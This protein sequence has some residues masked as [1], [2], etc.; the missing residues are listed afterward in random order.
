MTLPELAI[1]RPITTLVVLVSLLTLGIVALTRLPLAFM[2]DIEEPELYVHVS[3]PQ[4]AP[5][6]VEQMIARPLEDAVGSVKGLKTMWS[7]SGS[8]GVRMRLGFDWGA[9][10]HRARVEIWERIDR[11]RRDLPEDVGDIVVSRSW[12][13][14]EEEMENVTLQ[15]FGVFGQEPQLLH[16][17]RH[18]DL[19][20]PFGG[21]NTGQ[22]VRNRTDPA[23]TGRQGTG[24]RKMLSPKHHLE[25]ARCFDNLPFRFPE[26]ALFHLYGD[27]PVPLHPGEMF[28][29]DVYRPRHSKPSK[30]P[31]KEIFS[32]TS[33]SE[34]P[35]PRT[36]AINSATSAS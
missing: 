8:D 27:I 1:K 21:A 16:A 22:R 14:Q 36:R 7:R 30:P 32:R 11:I 24:Q 18:F 17:F 25:I 29:L 34:Y 19:K 6:Q 33:L 13:G 28:D 35:F 10:L 5:A 31:K 9:D 26:F 23:D 20:R 12:G 4:A 3:Y 2:P 15:R